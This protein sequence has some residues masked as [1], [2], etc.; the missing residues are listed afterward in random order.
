ML[1]GIGAAFLFLGGLGIFRFPDV[2]NRL[3]AGTKCT[4]LG[5]VCM[6]IGV[7]IAEPT[8]IFKTAVIA[9]FILLTNPI[10]AHA[11]AR[12]SRKCGVKLWEKSV[13]DKWQEL[14]L[15]EST[16]SAGGGEERG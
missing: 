11:L 12:A 10:S 7:G 8:W 15:R 1:M 13:V 5:A 2:Y 4:T 3:Q 9:A 14:A 6:I 16:T